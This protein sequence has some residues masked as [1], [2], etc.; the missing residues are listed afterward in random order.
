MATRIDTFNHRLKIALNARDMSAAELSRKTNISKSAISQYLKGKN[1]PKTPKTYII[2][3]ALSVNP[4]WLIGMDEVLMDYKFEDQ[5]P[6][7]IIPINKKSFPL[8][9][10]IAC[11]KPIMARENRESYVESGTELNADFCL[12]CKGDSMIGARIQDGD[13]VFIRKQ[14]TV[15]DGEIAAVIIR[16]KATNE[17]EATL[18]RVYYHDGVL[19]LCPE[20]PKYKPLI[21]T[22]DS[23]DDARIIGKAI[24]FESDIK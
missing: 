1:E 13:I 4:V 11:G 8:L 9:G 22:K 7:N 16:D 18:K 6:D 15:N 12:K 21:Y 5:T 20:N 3:R 14:D 23:T 17:Y 2:A 24:A 10:E 19:Q